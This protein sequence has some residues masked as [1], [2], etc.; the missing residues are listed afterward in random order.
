M[1]PQ[2]NSTDEKLESIRV[3]LETVDAQR[4]LMD[5]RFNDRMDRIA[6]NL[7]AATYQI[8]IMSEGLTRL[9]NT[10]NSGFAQMNNGFERLEQVMTRMETSAEQRFDRLEEIVTR[11]EVAADRRFDHLEQVVTRI[12]AAADRRDVQ[13]DR[14]LSIVER[15]LPRDQG[16]Q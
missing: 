2:Q 13:V 5:Q 14:L 10:V 1:S 12:E 16:V 8:G 4:A 7:E 9:E 3:Q 15:L 6:Q 11:M